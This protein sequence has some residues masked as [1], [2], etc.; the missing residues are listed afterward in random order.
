[1]CRECINTRTKWN[2]FANV[3]GLKGIGSRFD[4][5]RLTL[6]IHRGRGSNYNDPTHNSNGST[7]TSLGSASPERLSRFSTRKHEKV[8]ISVSYPSNENIP[9]SAANNQTANQLF[10]VHYT[11]NG[12]DTQASHLFRGNSSRRSSNNST[13]DFLSVSTDKLSSPRASKKMGKR[14]IKA[15]VKKF[16]METKGELSWTFFLALK[17]NVK[18]VKKIRFE[19][20]EWNSHSVCNK[21]DIKAR[22]C[23]TFTLP[24]SALCEIKV[25]YIQITIIILMR[26]VILLTIAARFFFWVNL[27]FLSP[28]HSNF[29]IIFSPF[30]EFLRNRTARH[31]IIELKPRKTFLFSFDF[32]FNF[33]RSYRRKKTLSTA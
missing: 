23:P 29:T 17:R 1:M 12:K 10:A 4:E 27:L 20:L 22:T 9:S 31:H 7:T 24:L 14:N 32:H 16:R 25:E 8:K 11:V 3:V 13:K 15:Q 33:N 2:H 26:S 28:P 6:R 5:Q 30:D 21:N 19:S 18:R